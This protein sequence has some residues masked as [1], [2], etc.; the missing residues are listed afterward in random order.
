MSEKEN[1]SVYTVLE[2]KHARTVALWQ[3][4]ALGGFIGAIGMLVA[5]LII[6]TLAGV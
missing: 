3:G 4:I 1:F 2:L 6:G 5:I